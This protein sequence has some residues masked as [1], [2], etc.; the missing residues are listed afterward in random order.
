VL[1]AGLPASEQRELISQMKLAKHGPNTITSKRALRDDL[2]DIGAEAFAVADEEF[3]AG[4]YAIA[5][6][7]R[8]DAR[9]VVAGVN[10]VAPASMISLDELV[11]KL[12]PHLASTA[13]G[14][15]ARLG[16]RREDEQ[17]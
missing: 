3:A 9:E 4:L 7:V 8:N 12:G 1:L 13:D 11:E 16:Y 17:G 14:I 6:A 5:A 10:L 2:E 15:S